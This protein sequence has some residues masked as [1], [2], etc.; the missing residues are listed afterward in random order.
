MSDADGASGQDMSD[1]SGGQPTADRAVAG[2]NASDARKRRTL[3]IIAGAGVAL[4]ALF[5]IVWSQG[6]VGV[7]DV[8][9]MTQE[10]ASAELES[11]G[12]NVGEAS[13]DPTLAVAPGT[14]TGQT[15]AHGTNLRE[16]AKVDLLVAELPMVEV[17]DLVGKPASEA[18]A[19]LAVAGL[20]AGQV[21][22]VSSSEAPE[23]TVVTQSPSSAEE[24]PVASTVDVE[25]STGPKADAVPDVTGLTSVDA[26]EVLAAAGFGSSQTSKSSADAAAGVVIEQSPVAGVTLQEGATVALTVSS[27]PASASV[28][29]PPATDTGEQTESPTAPDATPETPDTTPEAPPVEKPEPDPELSEVPDLIGMRVLEALNALRKEDLQFSIAWGPSDEGILRIIDQ[30]PAAGSK[31]EPGSVVSITIGLP[32]FLFDG[33]EVQPLPSEQPSGD[34]SPDEPSE[35]TSSAP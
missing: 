31:V 22:G 34:Q 23:G 21:T 27:G 9:G 35:L 30:D 18:E 29:T 1:G 3:W 32:S 20:R 13:S 6:N 8:I 26:V 28:P 7:P 33:V 2:P 24:V 19:D 16:G 14:V 10:Q 12:L 4:I 11:V 25:I 5:A 17:P 15:P